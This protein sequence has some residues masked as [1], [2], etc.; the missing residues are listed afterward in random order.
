MARKLLGC[1]LVHRVGGAIVGGRVVETEGYAGPGDPGSHAARAPNGRARIMFG[2]SGIA[3]VYF[4]YG[5]HHCLNA[6]TGAEGT[7]SAVLLR[8]LEPLWGIDQMRRTAPPTL[9]DHLLTSGPGRI[10]R[11]LAIGRDLNG[12]DL[13]SG[14]LQILRGSEQ[15]EQALSG[16]RVGLSTDDARL[17]RF[18]LPSRSVSRGGRT[19]A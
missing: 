16:L 2:R 10:C 15:R 4:T 17:W 8:A 1:F 6:V 5:M 11:A 7:A 19:P 13:V 18:W 9:P 3:Y 12:A 14:P